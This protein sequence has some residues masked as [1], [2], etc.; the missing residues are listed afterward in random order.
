MNFKL[1]EKEI[2][3]S[4]RQ[5]LFLLGK[6]NATNQSVYELSNMVPGI[7][8][9][10]SK[11][12]FVPNFFNKKGEE[13]FNCTA[14]Q[15]SSLGVEI[16][17]DVVHPDDL[18][19]PAHVLM[20]FIEKDD[21]TSEVSFFQR[22]KHAKDI[23]YKWYFTSCKISNNSLLCMSHAIDNLKTN[24]R[25]LQLLLEENAFLKKNFQK[26]N[27]LTKREKEVLKKLAL[28]Y[29]ALMISDELFISINTVKT[30]RQRIFKKLEVKTF[31]DLYRY[32]FHFDL[33]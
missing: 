14:D 1:S 26:F 31:T 8:H 27:K 23:D 29:T 17:K 4:L 3:E 10:N 20:P 25:Q 24:Q 12:N 30:H 6:N 32:A 2:L 7:L 21:R 15:V 33:L 19:I 28:G 16:I 11:E 9:I 13:I 18:Q 5:S 22:L